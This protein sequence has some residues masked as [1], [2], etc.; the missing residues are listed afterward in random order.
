M[1]ASYLSLL[2]CGFACA[3]A[4]QSDRFT[5]ESPA[6][7][8]LTQMMQSL[9]ERGFTNIAEADLRRDSSIWITNMLTVHAALPLRIA[10]WPPPD[11]VGTNR[12]VSILRFVEEHGWNMDQREHF[13]MPALRGPEVTGLPWTAIAE[14]KY[15]AVTRDGILYVALNGFGPESGGVAWNPRTN[16][17]DPMINGFKPLGGG[18]YYWKQTM[19]PS[20]PGDRT[21]DGETAKTGQQDGPANGSPPIRVQTNRTSSAAGSRR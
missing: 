5:N 2:V 11:L 10:D 8:P 12:M 21:Y 20:Q 1:K 13:M 16:P 18:W 4:E 14:L 6:T 3:A 9:H 15:P 19:S 7:E 17:F